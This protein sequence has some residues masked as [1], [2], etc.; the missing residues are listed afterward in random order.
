MIYL[1][2]P[3]TKKGK[4]KFVVHKVFL[5][6]IIHSTRAKIC[7]EIAEQLL[8]IIIDIEKI[9]LGKSKP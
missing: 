7:L 2:E 8:K 4:A 5:E 6:S 3:S 1:I 9:G